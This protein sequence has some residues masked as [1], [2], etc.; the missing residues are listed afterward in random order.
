MG[1]PYRIMAFDGGGIRGIYIA[2]LL[3]RLLAERPQFLAQ[4]DLLAG[5]SGGGLIALCLAAGRPPRDIRSFFRDWCP[6]I[7]KRSIWRFLGDMLNLVRAK[8]PNDGLVQAARSVLGE[9]KLGDV[10]RKVIIPAFDLKSEASPDDPSW[11]AR[12]FHNLDD[13]DASESLADL[14]IRTASAPTYFPSYQGYVDGGVACNSPSMLAVAQAMERIRRCRV[15][16]HPADLLRNGRP[17]QVH[18]RSEPGLGR[19]EVAQ[20]DHPGLHGWPKPRGGCRVPEDARPPVSCACARSSPT[21]R[22]MR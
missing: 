22:L 5:T 1:R 14:A 21:W 20:P 17:D 2:T 3:D 16:G 11:R 18:R 10:N 7:F 8:Y 6:R 12:F 13:N 15:G 19:R 9:A 4:T